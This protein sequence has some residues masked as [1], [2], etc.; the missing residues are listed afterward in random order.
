ML[1]VKRDDF[2]ENLEDIMNSKSSNNRKWKYYKNKS[3]TSSITFSKGK[4]VRRMV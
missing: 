3:K 1:E 4:R 2:D